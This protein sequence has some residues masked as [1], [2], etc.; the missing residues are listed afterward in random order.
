MLFLI[1]SVTTT[2]ESVGANGLRK[3]FEDHERKL[4]QADDKLADCLA[5]LKQ[6]A[7]SALR[8][9]RPVTEK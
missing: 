6:S 3:S 9:A 4:V 1:I 2:K 5:S 7:A 8:K